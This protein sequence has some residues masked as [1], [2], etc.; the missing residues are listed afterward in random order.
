MGG[1]YGPD[2]G[3]AEFVDEAIL[4]RAVDALAAPP[5]LRGIADDV[6]DP[7]LFEGAPELG[8]PEAIGRR[9]GRGGVHRPVR[10]IRVQRRRQ[11]VT[12]EHGAQGGHDR[13]G[14]LTAL[15]KLAIEQLLS[16]VVD[17]GDQRVVDIWI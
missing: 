17:E 15:D 2:P 5:R 6:L 3:D 12:L 7:E 9:A 8:E 14:A 4:Q 13:D 11:P 10:P 16:A 1:G